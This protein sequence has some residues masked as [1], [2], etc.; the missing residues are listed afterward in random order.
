MQ[1]IHK[2]REYEE[3]RFKRDTRIMNDK[4]KRV[5]LIIP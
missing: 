5:C 3:T 2:E 4:K 1:E